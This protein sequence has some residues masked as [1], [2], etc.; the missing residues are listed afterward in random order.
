MVALL[1]SEALEVI[2]IC[3]GPHD[4]LEG[5]DDFVAGRAVARRA[6]QSEIQ[7]SNVKISA[8][9]FKHFT[10]IIYDSRAVLTIKLPIL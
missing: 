8:N 9:L 3:S 1:T 2:D 7:T 4:H 5:R 10:F 6:E